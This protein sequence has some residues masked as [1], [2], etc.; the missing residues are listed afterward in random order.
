V[1]DISAFRLDESMP[2]VVSRYG[3]GVVLMHMRG[4]P[5][6]MHTLAPSSDIFSEVYEEL[7]IAVNTAYK[8][9]IGRDRIMLDPGIGFG[10]NAQ[11]SLQLINQLS[12]LESLQLPILVGTSRKSFIGEVLDKPVGERLL[13]TVASSIVAILGGAHVLRVHDVE[14]VDVAA[15]MVDA[16]LNEGI[17]E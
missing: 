16:I 1:N 4:I 11:E 7:Q 12:G 13:G 15:R 2:E 10:K 6:T 9:D 5:S 3:A 14:E 17:P 8:S